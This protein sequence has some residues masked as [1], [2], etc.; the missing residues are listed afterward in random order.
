MNRNNSRKIFS[1][2]INIVMSMIL[3]IPAMCAMFLIY[4]SH[5]KLEN[6][7]AL[8]T[9]EFHQWSAYKK[10]NNLSGDLSTQINIQENTQIDTQKTVNSPAN[11][12]SYMAANWRPIQDRI[13][14]TVVHVLTQV[15]EL[16]LLQPYKTPNQYS[17][18]GSGF[19]INDQGDFITNAHV[20]DQA[21]GI[22]IQIPSLGKQLL[23]VDV[24]GVS[25]E[26]DV[27]LVRVRPEGIASIV[28]ALGAIPYLQLGD[29]D[30]VHRADE[31]LALGYPLGQ[32]SLKSTTGVISGREHTYIQ[33]SAAI[34]PGSSGGPLLN[35]RGEVIG[36]NSAG[37]TAAQ[38]IGYIIPINDLKVVLDDLYKV[39]LLRK[40][41][42]GVLFNNASESLT[43]YLGNPAPGGCYVVEV[44]KESTLCNA[45]VQKGDMIYEINSHPIDLYGEMTVPWSEDKLSIIDYVARLSVGQDL[46]IVFYRNGDRKEVTVTFSELR[47][48]A[49]RRFYPGYEDLDYEVV[50]GM[51]V[52]PLT[53]NHITGLKANVPGLLKFTEL[54]YQSEPA[55]LITHIFPTSQLARSRTITP[56]STINEVN[57]R[58]VKTLDDL[59]EAILAS[60]HDKF[61]TIRASDH[62]SRSS[63]N[64]FVALPWVKIKEEE[65]RLSLDYHYPVSQTMNLVLEDYAQSQQVSPPTLQAKL[66]PKLPGFKH[67]T[68]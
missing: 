20:V 28:D 8:V 66:S 10:K 25:P 7:V 37:V 56:G 35:T 46:N 16:D 33:M 60:S 55:L 57:G 17:T 31:V 32:G 58:P 12:N 63:D 51:V 43:E 18:S 41:F 47:L 19:F 22:W 45:G 39:K 34:N 52:M 61:L 26:R 11:N 50:A 14:D 49:I 59:R 6:K 13:T 5:K 62:V 2:D 15:A 27:A 54:Q 44:L 23:D 38:N 24:I 42:L 64:V 68:A 30:L 29:S 36:I 21:K 40:P 48:P 53:L 9:R 65:K 67:V 1:I 3:V 4:L